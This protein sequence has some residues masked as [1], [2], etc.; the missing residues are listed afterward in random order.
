MNDMMLVPISKLETMVFSRA[1]V[2][3]IQM[4]I[5]NELNIDK[6]IDFVSHTPGLFPTPNGLL[7][8]TLLILAYGQ[9]MYFQGH[10]TAMC[11]YQKIPKYRNFRGSVRIF[12]LVF[13]ILFVKDIESV[14]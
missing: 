4:N 7:V 5:R 6:L 1:A 2:S 14:V 9:L 13:M 11:K 3:A 12:L 10:N 8:S